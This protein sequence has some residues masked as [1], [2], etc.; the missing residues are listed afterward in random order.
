MHLT[1]EA[2]SSLAAV[3]LAAGVWR[4][5]TAVVEARCQKWF[6]THQD[7]SIATYRLV[8]LVH[9][10]IQ[11]PLAALVLLDPRLWDD[12]L[13]SSDSLSTL[14]LIISASYFLVREHN[15]ASSLSSC[16]PHCRVWD[17]FSGRYSLR[18]CL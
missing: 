13:F 6:K 5:I 3:L 11:V 8:G 2:K 12:R 15:R 1:M 7:V 18:A 17:S 16:S 10:T 4:V 14:M 9:H